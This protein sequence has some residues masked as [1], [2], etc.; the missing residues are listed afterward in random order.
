MFMQVILKER[1]TNTLFNDVTNTPKINCL[2]CLLFDIIVYILNK[3]IVQNMLS[4]A[5]PVISR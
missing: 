4:L 2:C 3:L 5:S 1:E